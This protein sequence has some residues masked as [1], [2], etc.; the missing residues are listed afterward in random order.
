VTTGADESRQKR[1][2]IEQH[3]WVL[4]STWKGQGTKGYEFSGKKNCSGI[5]GHIVVKIR[6]GHWAVPDVPM[7]HNAFIVSDRKVLR[8]FQTSGRHSRNDAT[9]HQTRHQV[10]YCRHT[11]YISTSHIPHTRRAVMKRLRIPAPKRRPQHET[12]SSHI[13]ELSA[14]CVTSCT[15]TVCAENIGTTSNVTSCTSTVCA[16]NIRHN[17]S[18]Q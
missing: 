16:E 2:N 6:L 15:S 9:S 5:D 10:R 18:F 12:Y 13:R 1:G 11:L 8:L 17:G 4:N 3:D 7:K 14:F